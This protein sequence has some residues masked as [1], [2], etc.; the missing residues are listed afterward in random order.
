MRVLLCL[1]SIPRVFRL[2]V[3]YATLLLLAFGVTARYYVCKYM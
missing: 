3:S 2:G 1:I